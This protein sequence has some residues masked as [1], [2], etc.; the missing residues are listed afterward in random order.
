M[1]V[2]TIGGRSGSRGRRAEAS[3]R[4]DCELLLVLYMPYVPLTLVIF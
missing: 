4:L 3:E 2:F 1:T